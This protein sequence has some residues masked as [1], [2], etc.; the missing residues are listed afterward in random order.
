MTAEMDHSFLTD[1][2]RAA[3]RAA[4]TSPDLLLITGCG[5]AKTPGTGQACTISEIVLTLTGKLDDGPHPFI[6]DVIRRWVIRIQDA[7][8]ADIRNS[9]AWREAAIGIAG[10]AASPAVQ[11]K[12]RDFLLN[13]MWDALGD[14]AVLAG[15]PEA[16]RP[17]WDLMLSERTADAAYAADAAAYA[18]YAAYAANAAYAAYAYWGRRAL[19]STLAALIAITEEN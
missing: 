15:I 7:M 16:A 17:A 19:P 9:V 12:R 2:Q 11:R 8:P 6:C 18:A 10:S 3:I 5:T 14:G 1:E 13:W 4:L